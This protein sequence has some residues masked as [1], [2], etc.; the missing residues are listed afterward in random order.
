MSV[1]SLFDMFFL[2][3]RGRLAGFQG[4]WLGSGASLA[5]VISGYLIQAKGWRWYHWLTT[6][7]TAATLIATFFLVPETMYGRD[8]D[9]ALNTAHIGQDMASKP[10]EELPSPTVQQ[11]KESVEYREHE[12]A[13]LPK[14]TFLE[15]LK[16]WSTPNN[17]SLFTALLRPWVVL[18]YPSIFWVVWANATNFVWYDA[19]PCKVIL[20]I[21]TKP[22]LESSLQCYRSIYHLHLTT[23]EVAP[24]AFHPCHRLLEI[25]SA[26]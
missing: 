11:G 15:E 2:H 18:R 3:E 25:F 20:I 17:A 9:K 16:P 21:L 26:L 6:I 23:S 13:T 7:L 14:R 22:A 12:T 4:F 8:L 19:S 1:G 10:S 24:P 5:P